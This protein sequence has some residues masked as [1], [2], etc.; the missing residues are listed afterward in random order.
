MVVE[1]LRVAAVV[2]VARA[3]VRA[4]DRVDGSRDVPCCK[5]RSNLDVLELIL[6]GIGKGKETHYGR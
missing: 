5:Q 6:I 3:W 1:V 2:G 4:R